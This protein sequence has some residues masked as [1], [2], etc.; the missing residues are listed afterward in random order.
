MANYTK[1]AQLQVEQTLYD[2]IE[3]TVLAQHPHAISSSDFWAGFTALV[4]EFAPRNKALLAKRDDIQS[5]MDAWHTAHPGVITDMPGYKQFLR[6]IG[7]L[8]EE[9]ADF[10]ISTE[11]VDRDI[12][13]QAGPQLVVPITNARYALN[14]A[15]ARW[16]SLYDA[17]YGTDAITQ[18]GDLAPGKSY[19]PKRGD[20]VIAFARQFLDDSIP[21]T[22]GSHKDAIGY[23]VVHGALQAILKD[24]RQVGLQNPEY[25]A[26][27]QGKADAPTSLLFLHN[28]LYFDIQ[29]D[30]NSAIGRQDPAGIKDIIMEAALSTIMD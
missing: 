27:Y 26:G 6:E 28:G 7:Y 16:G 8:V 1:A 21:L 29:I 11:H 2:F 25:F 14:A 15:N 4:H 18:E 12:A 24:G 19:N 20:A 17:L 13:E 22:A 23:Q 5:K 10:T 30:K 3:N 9:P